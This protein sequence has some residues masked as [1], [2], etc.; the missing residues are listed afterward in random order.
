MEVDENDF[1]HHS[2]SGQFDSSESNSEE[3][4]LQETSYDG[5]NM[6]SPQGHYYGYNSRLDSEGGAY[7]RFIQ[8]QNS[9]EEEDTKGQETEA[10]DPG[11]FR[12]NKRVFVTA[13]PCLLLTLVMTGET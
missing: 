10:V 1:Y 6:G 12:Y 8:T 3:D 9:E 13:L 11:A 2:G 7:P 4:E 5:Y